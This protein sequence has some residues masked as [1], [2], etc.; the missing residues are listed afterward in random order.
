MKVFGFRFTRRV[1]LFFYATDNEYWSRLT[2]AIELAHQINENIVISGDLNSNLFNVNNNKLNNNKLVDLM[3][4]FNFRQ[5]Y[6]TLDNIFSIFTI[7]Q[8][9][10]SKKK[11]LYCAFID[12]EKAFDRVWR[13]GLFHKLL[14][15][16]INGKMYNIIFNM[17]T[18][19][20][21]CIS[22]NNHTTGYFNCEIGV[23]Q[24]ENL[25]PFLFSSFLND[26]EECLLTKDIVGLKSITDELETELEIY[27]KIFVILYA[28]DTILLAESAED[29]Q[30]QLN[31]FGEYCDNWKMKVNVN[32]TKIIVFGFGKLRQNL[33]FTYKNVDIE[34][35][36]QFNYLGV[37][38]TKTCNFDVTKKHL[39]DKALKAMHEVLKMGR[40]YKLSV[41]MQLDL[42]DK[43][44][45]PILLYGCEVWGFGKNEALERVHLKFCKIL[46]NLKSSTPNY[47]VYGEL[48]RY[49]IDI[50][51]KVRTISYWAR[52][53]SGKQAKFSNVFYRLSRNLNENGDTNLNWVY[54]IRTILNECGFTYIWETEN[55][56]NKEWLKCV[57]KQRLI[58]QFV[59]NWQTS[60]SDSSKALNY[61]IF[62]TKFEFEEYFNILNIGDAI[63]LCRIRTT[64]HYLP[65]ETGRWR[66]FDR[67]NRYCNLC[68]C[69]K[70]GDEYHYVL[71]CS[72]LN[73]KRKQLLPKYFMKR[74]NVVKFFEL[75]STKKQS[76]L[77][78]LC[79]FIKHINKVFCTPGLPTVVP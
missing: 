64:N 27:L 41:K 76:L 52:L 4:T 42:F 46:L 5:S 14:L 72:S 33:K 31:A 18:S 48:G 38:F 50:D 79:I 47:M 66:N 51:I 59:Q 62:K 69:Q 12:F 56:N 23:R 15:N 71:E 61:R 1:N 49:P 13:D 24:G 7:F 44:I 9:L 75:L 29:L 70:L 37:I 25:S 26:L 40:L 30:V 35:V 77:R 57:V 32:K 60:L 6:S 34:I 21:S 10:K 54:F 36:K 65:I 67:E 73:D 8:I 17:Y 68:N 2:H 16:N 55:V 19:V 78:K 45:K 53:L 20:K 43:M 22:Y 28:D 11:K 63:R 58:D 74:H 3:T 39:S